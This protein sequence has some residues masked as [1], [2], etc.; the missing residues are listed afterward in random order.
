MKDFL[1][2]LWEVAKIFILAAVIVIPIRYFLFQ[3]FVVSGASMEPSF[4]NGDYL[5]V[6]EISYKIN[7]LCRGDVVVFHYPLKPKARFIK[8]LIGLPGETV[9]IK[10]GKVKIYNSQYPVGRILDESAYLPKDTYTPGNVKVTLKENQYFM[11]GDNREFSFDSREWGPLEKKYIIGKVRFRL[12]SFRKM[13][14]LGVILNK[15]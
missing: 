7:P 14:S 12:F 11:M 6:D 13:P 4:D 1:S 3:T 5:I 10:D 9:E 8:R 15:I 2:F